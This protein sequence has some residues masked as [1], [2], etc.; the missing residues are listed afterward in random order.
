M[1]PGPPTEGNRGPHI[2][3]VEWLTLAF[4]LIAVGLRLH[5]R[6]ISPN[7]PGWDDYTIL[8]AT[9][10]FSSTDDVE[11]SSLTRCRF[12]VFGV[13]QAVVSIISVDNRFGHH[14]GALT[15][16]QISAI[17][18]WTRIYAMLHILGILLVRLSACLLVLRMPPVGETKQRHDRAIRMLMVIFI[19]I[20]ATSFFLLCF[21][22]TPIEG[23]WNQSLHARCIPMQTWD[24]I[25][26]IDGSKSS[27]FSNFSCGLLHLPNAAFQVIMNFLTASLPLIFL[28]SLQNRLR[29]KWGVVTIA[30]LAYL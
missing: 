14:V 5:S 16:D 30:F 3:T 13:A 10:G 12:Q 23:L 26:K 27:I 28:L 24:T 22:C 17:T 15:S 25:Q 29:E 20:S 9:V 11:E 18:M 6:C 7:I 8:A 1:L 19:V 2:L 21:Q 4:A